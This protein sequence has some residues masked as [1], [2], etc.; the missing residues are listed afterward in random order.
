MPDGVIDEEAEEAGRVA[1]AE[2][3]EE[4]WVGG[5]D[6]PPLGDE[7]GTDKVVGEA[8]AEEDLTEEVVV[9]ENRCHRCGRW[10]PS[11]AFHIL[12]G[13]AA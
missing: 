1:V 5:L 13:F 7:G 4:G 8:K 6:E 12:G 11:V 3:A 9:T 2:A 10:S